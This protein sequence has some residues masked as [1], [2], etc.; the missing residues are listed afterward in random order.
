LSAIQLDRV[1]LAIGGRTVLKD[2]S[3]A[4]AAGEF[5]GILGPN[6]AGKTTLLKGL[7]GL[8]RPS[9]GSIA[10]LGKPVTRGNAEIG[11]L[12]QTRHSP[13][14]IPLAGRDFLVSSLAG[15]RVGP[16]AIRDHK[17][18]VGR[19][20][21]LVHAEHLADR[22]MSDMSGG[23]R[24]RLLIAGALIGSPKILL[25]DEPL[26]GL[27]PYQQHVVVDLVRSLS[28]DLNLTVLFTAHE[29]NQLLGAVDRL[30]YLGRGQ[31]ALGTVAEVV[32]PDVLSRLYGAPIE[33]VHANGHIFV[34][35]HGQDIE[36]DHSHDHERPHD[37]SG[38][39]H[40]DHE[41]HDHA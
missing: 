5:I 33:V 27:D 2:V 20:L 25:L 38:H 30:L 7:L 39:P 24:Q 37:H 40:I 26:I 32:R 12:P 22:R 10:V 3:L 36:R 19:A 14:A 35:S 6:G 16:V 23:E 13:S 31:A 9:S 28:R 4:V 17:G 41:P 18:E 29:L 8:L 11:Y 34:M 1:T 15:Y 21:E